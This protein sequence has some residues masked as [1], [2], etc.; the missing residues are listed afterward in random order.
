VLIQYVQQV[1]NLLSLAKHMRILKPYR[2]TSSRTIRWQCSFRRVTRFLLRTLWCYRA[3]YYV[4]FIA[5]VFRGFLHSLRLFL[6]FLGTEVNSHE[7]ASAFLHITGCWDLDA[8]L[9]RGEVY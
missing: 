7:F 9:S 1:L 3:Q 8:S 4:L 5:W 2:G 6:A